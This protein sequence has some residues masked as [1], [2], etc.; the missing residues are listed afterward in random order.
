MFKKFDEEAKKVLVNMRSEMVNLR[1]PYIGSEHLFLSILKCGNKDIVEKLEKF[2]VT[3]KS[4]KTELINIVGL[5]KES[6]DFY[7]YTPLLRNVLQVASDN[8][9]DKGKEYV[10]VNDLLL[11]LLE[12]GDG[13]AIRIMMGMNINVSKMYEEFLNKNVKPHKKG[14]MLIDSFGVNLNEK[15]KNNEIDP[16]IGRDKE[17]KRMIEILS[18]RCKNNPLLIGEAG[19]GKTAI[20][21]ELARMIENDEVYTLKNKKIISISMANLVAG[22]KYRGEFEERLGKIIKELEKCDD[23]IIFIDEIHTLVGAGGAEGAI[24]ASNILKPAL[25]RG[26]IKLIGATTIDEYKKFIEKDKALERRFQVLEVKEPSLDVVS[27]ILKRLTPI[28]EGYHKVK[29]S[30][31]IINSIVELSDK[32]IYD[33]KMPDKAIDV[34][35]EVCS[36]VSITTS[37]HEEQLEN[38]KNKIKITKNLKNNSI[39]NNNFADAVSYKQEEN[40]LFD[41]LNKLEL[42]YSNEDSL[43]VVTIKDVKEVIEEKSKIPVFEKENS[44]DLKSFRTKLNNIVIGQENAVNIL[45]NTTK[46]IRYGY[47]KNSVPYSYLFIGKTGVGKTLLAKEYAKLCYG[48]DNFIR[49]DMSEY[50]EPHSISKLI[51]SPAGYVGYDD[52]KNVFEEVRDKPYSVILLDEVE[53]SC[54]EVLNLFLQILDEGKIKDSKKNTIRFDNTII[55]MTSNLGTSTS[56]IGFNSKQEEANF[57]ELQN[58]FGIEFLNRITNIIYFNSLTEKDIE[59]I[60]NKKILELKKNYQQRDIKF[61]INKKILSEI[62]TLCEYEKYGARQID[63]VISDYLEN[64]II[65]KLIEG[66]KDIKINKL[67][68]I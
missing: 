59:K 53:K 62:I 25:A 7:L 23:V 30:D 10:D 2:G 66:T 22:T 26:K 46:K 27:N 35:D 33:R 40:K 8:A 14:K 12:E 57:K 63:K 43:K 38:L 13:I 28:Y 5:G 60:V 3:Y 24:D 34:L 37:K 64:E 21:E 32:Y 42:K 50:K 51:G 9:I 18:R 11:A 19:V 67:V 1:H 45:Y 39:I 44:Q 55:I 61:T 6:N 58:F 49:I 4:F 54:K 48:M 41:E 31:A 20:V 16:V 65:D 52:N 68:K 17:I 29:L 47:K 15:V 56:N 36:K